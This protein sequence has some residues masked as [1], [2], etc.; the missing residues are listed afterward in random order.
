M[1]LAVAASSGQ[2]S[3]LLASPWLAG[4]LALLSFPQF[5]GSVRFGKVEG[6]SGKRIQGGGTIGIFFETK[7]NCKIS[8]IFQSTVLLL[9]SAIS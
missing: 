3:C 9:A 5:D 8:C 7:G 1:L 6:Q 4:L 2:V